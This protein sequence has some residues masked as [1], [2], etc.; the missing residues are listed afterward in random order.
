[1]TKPQHNHKSIPVAS[2]KENEISVWLKS[3]RYLATKRIIDVILSIVLIATLFIPVLLIVLFIRIESNGNPIFKQE[4][5]GRHGEPFTMYKLRTMRINSEKTSASFAGAND[6]RITKLG[7]FLRRTRIDETPQLMNVLIGDMS[8][9]GPRPEQSKLITEIYQHIPEFTLREIVRPGITG[10]A[11][12]NQ[13]Y[14][15]NI[16][17][18]KTKLEFDL[19]Y[20]KNISLFLDLKILMLTLGTLIHGRGAR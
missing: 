6:V 14:V 10:W 12:V 17:S 20:I 15:D 1:M 13:G 3:E 8:L 4:R 9:I 19:F 7:K 2:I 18:S 16:K 5:I 11:Q